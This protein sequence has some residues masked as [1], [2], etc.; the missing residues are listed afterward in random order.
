M[1]P[2]NA[3]NVDP[4]ELQR[5]LTIM[6]F[7][8]TVSETMKAVAHN[9]KLQAPP[10][11]LRGI[12]PI[13][14][15]DLSAK[16]TD[17]PL[18]D[19][20][21]AGHPRMIEMSEEKRELVLEGEDLLLKSTVLEGLPPLFPD[22]KPE[23]PLGL[24]LDIE[25]PKRQSLESFDSFTRS[26]V[27]VAEVVVEKLPH[28]AHAELQGD[29]GEYLLAGAPQPPVPINDNAFKGVTDFISE[30]LKHRLPVLRSLA[31]GEA[32]DGNIL[33]SG[34]SAEQQGVVLALDEDDL[35]IEQQIAIPRGLKLLCHL[36][37]A[38]AV[39]SQGIDPLKDAVGADMEFT[40]HGSVGS[41]PI[42]IE[43]SGAQDEAQFIT[44]VSLRFLAL[45]RERSLTV[46]TPP[47]PNLACP[48]PG[49]CLAADHVRGVSL[50][51]ETSAFRTPFFSSSL[52]P[53]V[54]IHTI[55]RPRMSKTIM[56]STT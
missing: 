7:Q 35:P 12:E 5:G 8:A 32:G 45:L 20:R 11:C 56:T 3:L 23:V 31:G 43:M 2:I 25:Q 48:Q 38:F 29:S 44:D 52:P 36:D 26:L 54:C 15:I 41:L 16:L 37:E 49:S 13:G 6:P 34:I 1:Y 22:L 19:V 17:D 21:G 39:L 18:N 28:V 27:Q 10:R 40:S 24:G 55:A 33:G 14:V 47:T 30:A 46:M 51:T 42:E 53:M 9:Q 50:G 4:G